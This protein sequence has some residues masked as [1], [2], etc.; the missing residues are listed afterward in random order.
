MSIIRQAASANTIDEAERAVWQALA[1][2]IISDELNRT[3]TMV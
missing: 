1:T 2:A 3:G